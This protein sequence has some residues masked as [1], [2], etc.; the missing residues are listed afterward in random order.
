MFAS[1][2]N[3]GFFQGASLRDPSG[4]LEGNG[5][6]MRHVTLRLGEKVKE[7]GLSALIE[8]AY[9]DIKARMEHG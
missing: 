5:R 7:A 3:V 2:V 8:A 4:L 6:F 1:H 9:E